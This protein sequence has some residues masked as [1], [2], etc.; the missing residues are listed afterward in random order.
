MPFR[1]Y[2]SCSTLPGPT[3]IICYTGSVSIGLFVRLRS[4]GGRNRP[5][6]MLTRKRLPSVESRRLAVEAARALLLEEGPQGVTLKAVAARINRTHA[7]LLH[8][9]GSALGLQQALAQH[10]A[11]TV[12][13]T[14]RD[15]V[16]ARRAGIG[17]P[18]E[19]VDI[20][21]DAFGREGGGALA[22]WMLLSG[23]ED[24]LNPIVDTIHEVVD[25]L[26]PGELEPGADRTMH[27]TTLALL[28]MALGDALMG[29]R[30]AASLQV[31]R[32]TARD[33]AEE[34]LTV[35]CVRAGEIEKP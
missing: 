3:E 29:K 26:H 8:H 27:E 12:S 1:H 13:E 30:F 17:S 24:A 14:I 11:V 31:R 25:E 32:D 33:K 9:F 4:G 2:R 18:R 20:T 23:N 7:N 22:S 28:L 10:L 16:R 5:D 21:F 34:M 35:S 15:A 6:H 19:V